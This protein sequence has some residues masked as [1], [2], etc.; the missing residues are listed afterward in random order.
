MRAFYKGTDK[1]RQC[2]L[3]LLMMSALSVGA[4]E[5][6]SINNQRSYNVSDIEKIEVI[7]VPKDVASVLEAQG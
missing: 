7:K 2:V 3:S 5:K 6:I 1:M 4:Q